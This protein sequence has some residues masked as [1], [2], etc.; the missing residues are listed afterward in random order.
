MVSLAAGKQPP[1]VVE[2]GE[3]ADE[4]PTKPPKA[5]VPLVRGE[6]IP[7]EKK[8]EEEQK[9]KGASASLL[10]S[11]FFCHGL[12]IGV[13]WLCAAVTVVFILLEKKK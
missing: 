4:K 2:E 9:K 11:C 8:E 13:L 5:D 7:L 1:A 10:C 6:C 12:L 3:E